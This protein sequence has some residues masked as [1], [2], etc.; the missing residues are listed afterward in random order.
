VNHWHTIHKQVRERFDLP[1]NS[2][3]DREILRKQFK[4]GFH[5]IP[6]NVFFSNN[7][8]ETK[9]FE[10]RVEF[11]MTPERKIFFE[12]IEEVGIDAIAEAIEHFLARVEFDSIGI[13]VH[14]RAEEKEAIQKNLQPQ[15]IRLLEEKTGKKNHFDAPNVSILVDLEK[16]KIFFQLKPVFVCGRYNK[17]SRSVAQTVHHCR[18]CRGRGCRNCQFSGKITADSVQEMIARSAEPAFEAEG[19]KFHGQGREDVDVQMLGTGR[20]FVFE[21]LNPKKRNMD[22]KELE[23]EINSDSRIRVHALSLCDVSVVEKTKNSQFDKIYRAVV[24]CE[25]KI[26]ENELE[27][28]RS[29]L[30][31]IEQQTPLRV[32]KRRADLNREKKAQIQEAKTV[33]G[34]EFELVVRASAGLYIKEFVSGDEGRTRPSVSTLVGKKCRC[35]ELDVLEIVELD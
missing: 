7:L 18:D 22:L 9:E 10:I 15:L 30:L 14:A 24:Q 27:K 8:F 3:Y 34:T 13:S 2:Q 28:L 20:R 12:K 4:K 5:E 1:L 29:A 32:V 6:E 16:K 23:K 19:N 17:F 33:S 25:E 35:T 31:S 11:Q 26:G 21:L